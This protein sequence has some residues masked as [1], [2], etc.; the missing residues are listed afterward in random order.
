MQ[1]H[2]TG[3]LDLEP[4]SSAVLVWRF[5]YRTVA[6]LIPMITG[7][8]VPGVEKRLVWDQLETRLL[9]LNGGAT[10]SHTQYRIRVRSIGGGFVYR[11]VRVV[12]GQI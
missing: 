7:G 3:V 11:L 12:F 4:N 9:F 6:S 10:P 8:G 1:I 2:V 5:P